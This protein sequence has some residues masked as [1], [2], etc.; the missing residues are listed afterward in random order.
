MVHSCLLTL[1]IALT[2]CT[3]ASQLA[4]MRWP[5]RLNDP[6]HK[7]VYDFSFT[8]DPGVT[9]DVCSTG[10]E[11]D[12]SQIIDYFTKENKDYKLAE[13]QI[14]VQGKYGVVVGILTES[15][16]RTVDKLVTNYPEVKT[17]ILVQVPGSDDGSYINGMPASLTGHQKVYSAGLSTCVPSN[18]MVASGGTDLFVSGYKKYTPQI[19]SPTED[20]YGNIRGRVGIHSWEQTEN[21]VA[22]SGRSFPKTDAVHTPY[23]NFYKTVCVSADFY[24]ET[25]GKPVNPMYYVAE[26]EADGAFKPWLRDCSVRTCTNGQIVH[27]SNS[28]GAGSS[29]II[30]VA[31]TT[32]KCHGS[33]LPSASN[34]S[35]MSS[36]ISTS[37]R[38]LLVVLVA[39]LFSD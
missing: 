30:V 35:E 34:S 14:F 37:L 38:S 20:A 4:G 29:S 3:V 21:G 1:C 5:R 10:C 6:V 11:G 32:T 39:L 26:T 8:V 12:Y 7:C 33:G 17:L 27:E 23:L 15:W 36:T 18:G 2:F 28:S 24:W 13:A 16:P 22:K 9:D 31:D 19:S 25:M